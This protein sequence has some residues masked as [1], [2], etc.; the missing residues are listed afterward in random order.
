MKQIKDIDKERIV[1]VDETG[2][3]NYLH[4]EYARSP[5]GKKVIERIGGKRYKRVNIAAGKIGDKIVAPMIYES[6]MTSCLF[7]EWVEKMLLKEVPKRSVIIMD[8]ATFHRKKVLPKI[9]EKEGHILIFLPPY[10]PELNPIEKYWGTLKRK[11][12]EIIHNFSSFCDALCSL[13]QVN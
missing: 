9:V 2:I 6:S 7:E 13:L 8:N 5:R 4:R 11:L 1:Y 12:K 3:N 10:S